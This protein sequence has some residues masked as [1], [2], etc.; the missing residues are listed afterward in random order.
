MDLGLLL[1]R[2]ALHGHLIDVD[3]H[4]GLE[5]GHSLAGLGLGAVRCSVSKLS[6]QMLLS[7]HSPPSL[8]SQSGRLNFA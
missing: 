7:P 3:G 6:P 4:V 8:Q 2:C 1:G 5:R